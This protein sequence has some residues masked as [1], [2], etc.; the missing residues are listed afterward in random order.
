M[1]ILVFDA[2][3]ITPYGIGYAADSIA[4]AMNSSTL[5]CTMLSLFNEIG[6]D[7]EYR[8]PLLRS[9]LVYKLALKLLSKKQIY[10]LATLR[11]YAQLDN[12]EAIHFWTN[13]N[14]EQYLKAKEKNKL[15]L[16]EA[17]NT[18]QCSA[19]SILVD[20]Y[21][22]LG[23]N[24]GDILNSQIIEEN[25]KLA[26]ADYI[27][28][29][30]PNVTRSMIE[31][32]IDHNKLIET[33]YGLGVHQR[34]LPEKSRTEHGI[35]NALFVG[36]GI[37]RKGIHLILDYWREADLKGKLVIVGSIDPLIEHIVRPYRDDPR[38]EFISFTRNVD[39]YFK[40]ADVFVLPSLEEGSPLVTY[41][42]I[43]AGLP[44]IVSPMGGE[45]VIR[46]GVDGYVI[47][48]HDKSQWI[49]TLKSLANEPEK[50]NQMSLAAYHRSE[51]FLWH[52]VGQRRADALMARIGEKQ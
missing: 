38:F 43:G 7:R 4:F 12:Y 35:L 49:S 20:E 44:C 36:S 17:I 30:S 14:Y 5:K 18:H 46:D 28:C 51:Y 45:G 15:I 13:C 40:N 37:I 8:T 9:N 11:M 47:E 25:R 29:P 6:N 21:Q 19:R 24:Y 50:R 34:Y 52:N 1:K 39:E 27:F 2:R 33:S 32:G 26:L 10:L 48:P 22:G 31:N 3:Y 42:A 16:H 41:L 23:L